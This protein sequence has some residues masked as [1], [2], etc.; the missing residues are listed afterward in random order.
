MRLSKFEIE[1]IKNVARSVFGESVKV[2]LFGS[3]IDDS[4]KGGDIDLLIT[5]SDKQR[6][7]FQSKVEFLVRLKMIIGDQKIDIVLDKYLL[8]DYSGFIRSIHQTA[9]EI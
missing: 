5:C 7:T 4:K 2:K 3:R 6:L 9:I 1:A 8:D